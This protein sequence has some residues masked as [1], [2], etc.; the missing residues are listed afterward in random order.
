MRT[1]FIFRLEQ[2]LLVLPKCGTLLQSQCESEAHAVASEL[3]AFWQP[4]WNRDSPE[5]ATDIEQWP[6]FQSSL[7]DF[8]SPCRDIRVDMGDVA[9]WTHALGLKSQ[10]STGVRLGQQSRIGTSLPGLP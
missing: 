4:V 3:A 9:A 10:S 8:V 5:A 6:R 1:P 2:H 7:R